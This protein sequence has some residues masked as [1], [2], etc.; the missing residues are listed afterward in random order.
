MEKWRSTHIQLICYAPK[1]PYIHRFGIILQAENLWSNIVQS[2]HMLLWAIVRGTSQI[3]Q[4]VSI[5][6]NFISYMRYEDVVWLDVAVDNPSIVQIF[7]RR[8]DLVKN[9]FDLVYFRNLRSNAFVDLCL[10]SILLRHVIEDLFFKLMSQSSF[11]HQ[12]HHFIQVVRIKSRNKMTNN[13]WMSAKLMNFVLVYQVYQLM[14]RKFLYVDFLE[15]I[16]RVRWL[17]ID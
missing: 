11:L 1:W 3:S 14:P 16:D 2:S 15:A 7:Q 10:Q 6:N 17:V 4:F 9:V 8:N 12:L 5:L 13:M